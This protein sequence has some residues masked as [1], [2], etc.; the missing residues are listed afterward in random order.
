MR[1]P[2]RQFQTIQNCRIAQAIA[3]L[4][5]HV[6]FR[7]T[8]THPGSSPGQAFCGTC[9]GRIHSPGTPPSTPGW[10]STPVRGEVNLASWRIHQRCRANETFGNSAGR[11]AI[12]AP[13]RHNA[14]AIFS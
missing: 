4:F 12:R 14:A 6:L 1:L 7:K 3:D 10:R 8:G 9:D 5:A 11:N 2:F 13:K